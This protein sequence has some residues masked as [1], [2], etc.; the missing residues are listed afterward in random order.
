[1]RTFAKS[2]LL[3]CAFLLLMGISSTAAEARKIE[4]VSNYNWESLMAQLDFSAVLLRNGAAASAYIVVYDGQQTTRGEVD[5]W[6]HCIK[7]YM[8]AMRGLEA[9]RIR[10]V[11]GGY[12]P[13][14][15][16]ELWRINAGAPLP[17]ATPTVQ[18]KDVKFKKGR[19]KNWQSLC[20]I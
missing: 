10:I 5:G 9:S 11:N 2:I 14:K 12:R 6:M 16:V 7:N 17:K 1:M 8:V 20:N 4:E 18:P 19:L 13:T 3:S 15:T